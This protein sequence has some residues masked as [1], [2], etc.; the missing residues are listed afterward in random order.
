MFALALG[1]EAQ[2]GPA[3]L[4]DTDPAYFHCWDMASPDA[5][6]PGGDFVPDGEVNVLD[7]SRQVRLQNL[8]GLGADTFMLLSQAGALQYPN[9]PSD[10]ARR[11]RSMAATIVP[12][13]HVSC[14]S[15]LASDM[16]YYDCNDAPVCMHSIAPVLSEVATGGSWYRVQL[17]S[18]WTAFSLLFAVGMDACSS[19][20]P[21]PARTTT[22]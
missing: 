18:G 8:T 11:R 10:C 6:S 15:N 12:S 19:S 16:C 13:W 1:V 21:Y 5:L 14:P 9:G 2:C 22:S 17:P 4:A 7:Y 3:V 20:T